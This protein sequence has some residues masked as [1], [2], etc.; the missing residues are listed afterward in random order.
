[1]S[2]VLGI[3]TGSI[4]LVDTALKARDYC[5]D[6]YNAPA[7]QRK[8]FTELDYLTPLLVE[9]QKRVAASRS[10]S[11]LQNMV[12]PLD[13][14]KTMMEKF[15]AKFELSDG[16][17]SKLAKRFSWTLW[18]K[19]EAKEY[20]A[21]FESVKSL[22]NTWL[23]VRNWDAG[24]KHDQDNKKEHHAILAV[25]TRQGRTQEERNQEA[26]KKEILDWITPLNFFQR[27]DDIFSTWQEG[28]G[29]WLLA[30]LQF[31]NWES[32]SDKILWCRGIPGA[33]KTVLS[34][35]VVNHLRAQFRNTDI[36]VACI[37]LNHKETDVQTPVN[38]L[39]SLWKQLV[40]DTILPPAVHDLYKHHRTRDTRPS[41]AEVSEI[42]KFTVA[43]HSRV[44]LVVDALD[45]YFENPRNI[46]LKALTQL[47]MATTS[48]MFTS[49]LHITL[50]GF[51]PDLP[52]L[53]IHASDND[54]RH[55]VEQQIQ[56]SSRLS[57]H[58]QKRPE[59]RNEIT[60]KIA[61]NVQGM[62]LLAKLHTES[63]ATKSTIRAVR[64]ALQNLPTDLKHTY[65]EAMH[66]IHSQNKDDKELAL[67][68]LTW[69][70]YAKR[71]LSVGELQEAMAIEPDGTTLDADNLLDINIVLSVCAGLLI[72]D[73]A[74][75]VV[76]LIHY[77]AQSFFDNIGPVQF[78]NADTWITS[79]CLTYL[80]FDEFSNINEFSNI[81]WHQKGERIP[82]L[83]RAHPLVAYSQHFL[84]H[85]AAAPQ[86]LTLLAHLERFVPSATSWK[87][88][89]TYDI[90]GRVVNPWNY[91]DWPS[92]PSILWIL[93]ASNLI[94]IVSDFLDQGTDL[95]R[96]SSLLHVTAFYGHLAMADLLVNFGA[97]AR[98]EDKTASWFRT[99]L[100]AASHEGHEPVVRFLIEKG[101][102]VNAVGGYHGPALQAA[103]I[104]G[105]EP[106][107]RL[108]IEKG[109]D[110]NAEGGQCGTALQAA[111]ALGHEP[112]VRLLIEKGADV[113][114]EGGQCGTALQAACALGHEPV[115]RLL[116][117]KGAGV[118]AE[119]GQCGT[120]LQAAS[121]GGHEP[122]VRFLIEKGAGVTA[123]GGY[124]GTALQAASAGGHEPVVRFL[125]EKGAGV[126]AVGGYYG[127]A[128]Q[129]ASAGGHE[130][131]VRFLIEKG[132]DVNA[133][134]G[135]GGT[136]LQAASAGGHEPVV[137]FLIEKGAGVTA[138]GGYY[139]T[140]LQAASAG[141]HEPVVRFLIEKG[142][143]VNAEGGRG[144]TALQAASA[145]G[146]E[147]VVRFLIE[148]GADVTAEGGH[149]GTAL[150][151]ASAGGHEPVVRFLIEKGA[152]VTAEGGDYGT[153]LQ[154][155]SAG[156]HEPVVR[157]L[158][159]KGADVTAE[160][161]H[162]GTAL[163]AA[164]AGG[165]EPVVRFLIEKGADVTA[166]G[167]HYGTALQ[168]ASAEGHEPVVRFL[169]EKGADVTAEGGHYGTALQAASAEGHEPVVRFLIEKGADV[170]A[171]GGDYGTALQAAAYWG[172]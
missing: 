71:P 33:G 26:E 70:A 85:A 109:A 74:M 106:V 146:H 167:G 30:D 4:Q 134:G 122:V 3:V 168:A 111:C 69:V 39:A 18:N 102:D 140:A 159:E 136:A 6:F 112:V 80:S 76:R 149:Y 129:A 147:P 35:L 41:L 24:E 151:A 89:W 27:Q 83:L 114:A 12:Q 97:E 38:L 133:E 34:S 123:E 121:A 79:Q 84:L 161:G 10:S 95:C 32:G 93:A 113:N 131:V 108:L 58:V 29:E 148:K 59:L 152:D 138:V 160:G 64:D 23:A 53:E 99:A 11:V 88:V 28:T 57:R 94:H 165:H 1:M 63:L 17:W 166:E 25:I 14:F 153:A 42:L 139:G 157:F 130:P 105:H 81:P 169:I 163:Q 47:P 19:K 75:S 44:Y 48:L 104:Q 13:G 36:G 77:T 162:Y 98:A 150:Q 155:A 65:D 172:R 127:T 45:E 49:R 142:A 101:A 170:T 8:L 171:E 62:F 164:S 100:K 72:I 128:L 87:E 66:R 120:A 55:Y 60:S 73:E 107:V 91:R 103:S 78:P 9:L 22:L 51:F 67:Q 116:I 96:D 126:T 31:K 118:N 20:L 119:G 61:S 158:I 124:Y 145:G 37:Y 54:I 141:G 92:S 52:S 115:V 68:A 86:Q 125:I 144:G 110:V 143:D 2:E 154:A 135:R 56:I 46:L 7:E 137:R 90:P 16:Q 132:A 50:D 15:T 43:Q 5:K 40:V 82:K 156:G 117:E 21:E